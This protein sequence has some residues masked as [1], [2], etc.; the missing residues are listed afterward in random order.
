[1]N[2]SI[3]EDTQKDFCIGQF[4]GNAKKI[5]LILKAIAN[6]KRLSIMCALLEQERSVG[7]LE[8]QINISQSALSQH[9]AKLRTANIVTT[10]RDAQTIYYSINKNSLLPV[11][12]LFYSMAN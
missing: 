5:S 10:R 8:T 7:D 12:H 9:L 3:N 1:M 6:E 4:H 2:S 11:L